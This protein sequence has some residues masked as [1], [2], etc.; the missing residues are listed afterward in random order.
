MITSVGKRVR[1]DRKALGLTMREL[2]EK[3]TVTRSA[4]GHIETG[5]SRNPGVYTIKK[6]AVALKCDASWLAFG[7]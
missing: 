4:I 5:R 1:S 2:A 7:E 6:L 3:S